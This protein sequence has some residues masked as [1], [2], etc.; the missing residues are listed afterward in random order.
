MKKLK[1]LVSLFVIFSLFSFFA[2]NS[3]SAQ[4]GYKKSGLININTANVAK[5][6]KLPGIG[7]KKAER[8]IKYRKKNGR[9]RRK[10]EIMKISGIGEK[11]YKKF[12]KMITAG[13]NT[14][15]KK[16]NRRR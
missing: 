9:F 1:I 13:T 10:Q 2:L 14:S 16:N 15:V 8:I 3:F 11:T 4:K 7:K 12:E 6:S 5:L